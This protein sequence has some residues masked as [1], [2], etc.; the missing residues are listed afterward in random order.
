MVDNEEHYTDKRTDPT[1]GNDS[2]FASDL[3]QQED[4]GL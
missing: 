4:W 2:F 1:M 3:P